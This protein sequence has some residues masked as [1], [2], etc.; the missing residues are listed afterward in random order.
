MTLYIETSKNYWFFAAAGALI[1]SILIYAFNSESYYSLLPL[2][3]LTCSVMYFLCAIFLGSARSNIILYFL[4]AL[5]FIRYCVSPVLLVHSEFSSLMKINIE[6]NARY[7]IMLMIYEAAAVFTT[8]ILF[9][10]FHTNSSSLRNR[11][12]HILQDNSL[13]I[14]LLLITVFCLGVYLLV[15]ETKGLFNN[16]FHMSDSDFTTVVFSAADLQAGSV[17]RILITLFSMLFSLLRI[18][19]PLW[20]IKK[21]KTTGAQETRLIIV[22]LFFVFLQFLFITSTFAESVISSLIIF[23]GLARLSPKISRQIIKLAVIL[24][25]FI[26]LL[27]FLVRYGVSGSMYT[28]GEVQGVDYISKIINSYFTGVDNVAAIFNTSSADKWSSLFYNLY[29]AIPFNSTLFGLSGAKLQKVYNLSNNT[30]GQIPPTIASGYYYFGPVF[31]VAFSVVLTLLA[32]K[33]AD[34][35]QRTVYFWRYVASTLAA[36]I[37]VFGITTYNETIFLTSFTSWVVPILILSVFSVERIDS[38]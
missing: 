27:F 28:Q 31:S 20:V 24:A 29:G 25:I 16:I 35:A 15:P 6:Y 36:I 23:L 3:P 9:Q 12:T 37:A 8:V 5:T 2:L 26:V 22:S 32:V 4:A 11:E 19:G 13:G 17:K 7:A 18:M 33:F 1:C 38:E 30:Y 21:M 10:T 14:I 34:I